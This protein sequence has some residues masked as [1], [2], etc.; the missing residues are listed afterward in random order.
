MVNICL[1]F[2]GSRILCMAQ[3]QIYTT[4]GGR[5]DTK[6][7]NSHIITIAITIRKK[8]LHIH[9]LIY[10]IWILIIRM[11]WGCTRTI[12]DDITTTTLIF[13]DN[14]FL[15]N[16]NL[17]YVLMWLCDMWI[18]FLIKQRDKLNEMKWRIFI[19][20]HRVSRVLW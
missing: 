16:L 9:Q 4:V 1:S 17:I 11:R 6:K 10:T 15:I 5:S 13:D 18:F 8:A 7:N 20:N 3:V 14:F 19:E 12:R 2:R